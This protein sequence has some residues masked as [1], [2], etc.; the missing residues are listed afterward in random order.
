[1]TARIGFPNQKGYKLSKFNNLVTRIGGL[2]KGVK[3]DSSEKIGKDEKVDLL[4]QQLSTTVTKK[5]LT[6][7]QKYITDA[8]YGEMILKSNLEKLR[9]EVAALEKSLVKN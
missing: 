4:P 1:M 3:P 5:K 9:R 6:L 8:S 7:I 2:N